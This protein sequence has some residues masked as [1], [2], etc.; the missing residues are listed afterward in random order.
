MLLKAKET[1]DKIDY[2]LTKQA[3]KVSPKSKGLKVGGGDCHSLR[4]AE[5]WPPSLASQSAHKFASHKV[6]S[7]PTSYLPSRMHLMSS[8]T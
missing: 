5:S 7:M 3:P 2:T 6:C 1:K 4:S 8:I